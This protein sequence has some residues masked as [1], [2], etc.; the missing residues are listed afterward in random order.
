MNDNSLI[1][2][3]LSLP[4]RDGDIGLWLLRDQWIN[5]ATLQEGCDNYL[6]AEEIA[7]SEKFHFDKHR[8]QYLATR[9]LVRCVLSLYKRSVSPDGWSFLKNEFG[10]P[11]IANA[12]YSEK[13]FFNIS[14]TENIVVLAVSKTEKIGVDIEWVARKRKFIDLAKRFFSEVEAGELALLPQT[15]QTDRFYEIWTLKEAYIKAQGEG[16]SIPLNS[17]YFQTPGQGH[18]KIT[19]VDN[20]SIDPESWQFWRFNLY[21]NYRLAIALNTVADRDCHRFRIYEIDSDWMI[22]ENPSLKPV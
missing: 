10:R 8:K 1:Q 22:Q 13:L 2:T 3:D 21:E 18:D 9:I 19:F 5:N 20:K 11:Y 4:I 12:G 15:Q 7:K 6:S 14:H 17:F 16:L